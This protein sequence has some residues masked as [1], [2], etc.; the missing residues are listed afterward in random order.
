MFEQ[1]WC[2]GCAKYRNGA[3]TILFNTMI[4]NVTDPD[5]PKQWQYVEDVPTCTAFKEK[6]QRQ[7]TAQ[8]ETTP[9]FFE[10]R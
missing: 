5:Y 8:Q 2:H 7:R 4:C 1:K 3:C 10:R 9:D 6:R